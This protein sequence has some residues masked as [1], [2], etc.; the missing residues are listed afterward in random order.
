MNK[1]FNG[2]VYPV[3]P[4]FN[5]EKLDLLSITKYIKF[6]E[7]NGVKNI[8][9]TAGSSQFNLLSTQEILE[10]NFAVASNFNHNKIL[11]LPPLS[12]FH[13]KKEIEK[14]NNFDLKDTYLLILFPERYYSDTQVFNYVDEVCSHSKY[15]VLLHGNPLKRGNGGIYEYSNDLLRKLSS[16]P[17]FI[18]IKEEY[19]SLDLSINSIQN[20]ELEIIV[21][22]GS[23]RRYWTLQPFGATTFLTGVGSFNPILSERFFS[24]F[25]QKSYDE[26]LDIIKQYETPLF[27]TFMKIGWHASMRASLKYLDFILEDRAPFHILSEVEESKVIEALKKII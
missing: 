27:N 15:P 26:C 2:P 18:G 25:Q 11:G 6:L 14:L 17:K 1:V 23:M 10:L 24:L 8:V 12:L 20:L 4:S 16:I 22:G 19:S 5:Q 13:I 9:T 21:A 7:S 3:V